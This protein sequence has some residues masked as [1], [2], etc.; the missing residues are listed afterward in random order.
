MGKGVGSYVLAREWSYLT[1]TVTA[2]VW[3]TE[4]DLP[5]TIT[6]TCCDAG[7]VGLLALLLLLPQPTANRETTSSNPSRPIHRM[8]LE[9]SGFLLRAVKTV[10]N[11]PRGNKRAPMLGRL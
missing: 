10:P 9:V 8:L 5:V 3:L 2:A 4:P 6:L 7:V 11:S 1:V